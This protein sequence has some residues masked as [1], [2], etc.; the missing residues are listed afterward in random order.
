MIREP[1]GPLWWALA[2]GVLIGLAVMTA[3]HIQLGG[4]V[5]AL[6]LGVSAVGRLVLPARV[7]GAL[8][9]RSALMDALILTALAAAVVACVHQLRLPLT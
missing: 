6:A 9:V 2:L 3:G 1:L 7:I 5:L 8:V 4:D